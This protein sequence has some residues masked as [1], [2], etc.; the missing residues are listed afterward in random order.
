MRENYFEINDPS[1]REP[2]STGY[3]TLSKKY[4]RIRKEVH[5]QDLYVC[6]YAALRSPKEDETYRIEEY[7]ASLLSRSMI[8]ARSFIVKKSISW[9]QEMKLDQ[10]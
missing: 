3:K 8:L 9:Y 6:A 5:P 7:V 1:L 10:R 2:V 4:Y